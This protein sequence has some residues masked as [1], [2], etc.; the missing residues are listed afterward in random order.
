MGTG[1]ATTLRVLDEWSFGPIRLMSCETHPRSGPPNACMAAEKTGEIWIAPLP[2][3]A[4][5]WEPSPHQESLFVLFLLSQQ[6]VVLF[7]AVC[8]TL[9][10]LGQLTA[11]VQRVLEPLAEEPS[12]EAS[13]ALCPERSDEERA[14]VALKQERVRNTNGPLFELGRV[15]STPGALDA[16]TEVDIAAALYSHQRGD[17]GDICREDWEENELSLREGYRLFSV[18]YTADGTKFW[19][20]TEADRSATT[21]ELPSD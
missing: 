19:V 3:D 8:N 11:Q 20:I 21:L 5:D 10:K 17:W 9:D 7:E 4:E 6:D 13:T 16:L 18:Y 12:A 2:G 14:F 15:V 1:Y